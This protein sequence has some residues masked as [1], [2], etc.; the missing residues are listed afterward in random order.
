MSSTLKAKIVRIEYQE[1]KTGLFYAT[2]PNLRGLVIGRPSLTDLNEAIPQAIADLYAASG[3]RVVVTRID[4][5]DDQ[6]KDA[7]VA[8]PAEVARIALADSSFA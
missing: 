1:G 7:W 3:E 2:S 5:D 8:F 4:G 6:E